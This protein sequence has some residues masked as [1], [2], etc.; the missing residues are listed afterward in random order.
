MWM[1]PTTQI[2]TQ[3]LEAF[4]TPTPLPARTGRGVRGKVAVFD[5]EDFTHIRPA[6]LGTKVC[7]VISTI[8]RAARGE[9]GGAQGL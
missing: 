3:T 9:P 5:V 6:D 7:V 4:K 1:V 2:K 8:G